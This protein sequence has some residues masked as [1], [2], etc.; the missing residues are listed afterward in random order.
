MINVGLIRELLL[1]GMETIR[2]KAARAE[3][4]CMINLKKI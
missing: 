3:K 1:A 2:Q 4:S